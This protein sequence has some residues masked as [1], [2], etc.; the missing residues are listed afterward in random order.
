MLRSTGV[1]WSARSRK[2][3]RKRTITMTPTQSERKEQRQFTM[4]ELLIVIGIMM[5]LM[6]LA[7]PGFRRLVSGKA[8]NAAASMLSGQLALARAAAIAEQRYIAVIMPGAH[9]Q[10]PASAA[11]NGT[12]YDEYHFRSFR[13]GI[14]EKGAANEENQFKLVSWYPDSKWTFLPVGAI[15]A[16]C[17]DTGVADPAS[18]D[19][20]LFGPRGDRKVNLNWR[21]DNEGNLKLNGDTSSNSCYVIDG[22]TE[23]EKKLVPD[24]DKHHNGVNASARCVVFSPKGRCCS[25][26]GTDIVY[27]NRYIT[28]VEGNV[29]EGNVAEE[30]EIANMRVLRLSGMTGRCEFVKIVGAEIPSSGSGG[31]GGGDTG[32]GSGGG[33]TGGGSSGGNTNP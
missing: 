25:T 5:I 3:P 32:G 12:T 4:L 26:D 29:A 19:I 8:V 15:L 24:E 27:V 7:V 14:V 28:L 17:N 22:G 10:A 18:N 23:N 21:K 13:I 1:P 2:Q 20:E 33:D 30:A 9:F 16:E 11:A 31:G 6:S